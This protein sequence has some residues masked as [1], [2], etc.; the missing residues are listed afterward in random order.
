MLQS[1]LDRAKAELGYPLVS[2]NQ[3]YIG[4]TLLFEQV[5]GPYMT[6]GAVTTSSSSLAGDGTPKSITLASATGFHVGDVVVVDVDDRQERVTVQALSGVTLTALF[7]G[8]H[9]GSY[10]VTVEGGE[11]LVREKLTELRVA[12]ATRAE[13]QGS[14][15]VKAITGDIEWYD[16]G[17]SS[18][19]G[20][21]E[22][23][24]VLRDELAAILGV[25]N[26]WNRKRSA[27]ARMS[28]Y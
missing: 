18:F 2:Q 28:V 4:T 24:D 8:T 22:E 14:G 23:I 21:N 5:V 27:G 6:S 9:S 26:L 10:P 3:P 13:A 19:A 12:H 7:N 25:E 20:S 17:K 11:S 15:A 16:T 1:E